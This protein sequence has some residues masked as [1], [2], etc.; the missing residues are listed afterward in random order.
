MTIMTVCHTFERIIHREIMHRYVERVCIQMKGGC[1]EKGVPS[2]AK[3]NVTR[4]CIIP[5]GHTF[6]RI[7]NRKIM[8][9][10]RRGQCG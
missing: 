5:V 10:C 8:H 7:I 3:D 6:K 2:S 1:F 9:I 4:R